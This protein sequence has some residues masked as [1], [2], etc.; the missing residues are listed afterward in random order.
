MHGLH[1]LQRRVRDSRAGYVQSL[2]VLRAA[3]SCGVYTKSSIMLGLGETDDEVLDTLL[4]LEAV[5]VDIVTFGQYLQPTPKHL[6][7]CMLHT[8]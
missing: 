4:D 6:P 2:E 7:V 1:R 8:A 3:K 5:G